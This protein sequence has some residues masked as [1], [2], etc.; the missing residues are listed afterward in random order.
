MEQALKIDSKKIG[1]PAAVEPI[2]VYSVRG[3]QAMME[4]F[5]YYLEKRYKTNFNNALN[6]AI[7][8]FVAEEDAKQDK[9]TAGA[10]KVEAKYKK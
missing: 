9:Y 2:K 6:E 3:K 7:E 5:K 4:K 10:Q 1:R 8:D